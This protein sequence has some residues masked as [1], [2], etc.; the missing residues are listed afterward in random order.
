MFTHL[1]TAPH[2]S[3]K[4]REL[5]RAVETLKTR[6]G[7]EGVP[8]RL[9]SAPLALSANAFA[10]LPRSQFTVNGLKMSTILTPC[11]KGL[12]VFRD[13]IA[14]T[15]PAGGHTPSTGIYSVVGLFRV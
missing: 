13:F 6:Y 7:G 3:R 5:T 10:S 8:H 1:S 4:K 11:F 15:P 9:L 14:P 12:E 2:Q